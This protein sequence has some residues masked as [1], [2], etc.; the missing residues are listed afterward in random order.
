MEIIEPELPEDPQDPEVPKEEPIVLPPKMLSFHGQGSTYFGIAFV[1]FLLTIFTLGLYYPWAKAKNR[2][3]IWNETELDGS[4]FVFHGTGKEMFRGFVIAYALLIAFYF[5]YFKI[6]IMHQ[7]ST[8]AISIF[9]AL[10]LFI[11]GFFTPLAIFGAWRYRIS[12]TSWRGIYF[13]YDGKFREFYFMY[14]KYLLITICTLGI[15]GA[16]LRVAVQKYLFNHTHLGNYNFKFHGQ[17]DQ[18]FMIDL[19]G[20]FLSYIT[21]FI[22]IPYYLK[23]RFQFTVNYTT[24]DDEVKQRAFVSRLQGGEAWRTLVGNF[25]LLIITLGL[26]FP[27]TTIANYKLFINHIEVPGDI[28]LNAIQQVH[29]PYRNATGDEMTDILDIDMDF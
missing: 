23:N 14:L 26:A 22:Y 1:N 4:R 18:L 2:Q 11:I 6:A 13:S 28:D 21:C 7:F 9:I 29:D 17:G 20:L 19:A 12:R 15:G 24:V 25:L 5:F 10:F 16:W 27:F 8:W 3:Y